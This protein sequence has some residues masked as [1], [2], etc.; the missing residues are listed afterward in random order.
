MTNI[1]SS[2]E[3]SLF[4]ELW[5]LFVGGFRKKESIPSFCEVVNHL[6]GLM[7][8]RDV[9]FSGFPID[10]HL[11]RREP[12]DEVGVL[13]HRHLAGSGTRLPADV[14]QKLQAGVS[15]RFEQSFNLQSR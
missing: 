3:T 7:G 6:P 5:R 1:D 8:H 14:H 2:L 4:E 13:Q 15:N 11:P 9:P 10:L 12:P